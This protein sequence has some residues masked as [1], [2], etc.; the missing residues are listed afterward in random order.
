MGRIERLGA[1]DGPVHYSS[2]LKNGVKLFATVVE[3]NSEGKSIEWDKKAHIWAS[4]DGVHWEDVAS[5]KKDLWPYVL[6]FGRVLFAHGQCN[7]D[8]V[9][10]TTQCLEKVDNTSFCA[11]V[12]YESARAI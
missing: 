3:G 6:G 1:V 12:R 10:F 7:K 9:F 4:E 5:W 11:A 2:C 8:A